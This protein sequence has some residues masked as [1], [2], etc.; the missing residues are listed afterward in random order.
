[1]PPTPIEQLLAGFGGPISAATLQAMRRVAREA[2][3]PSHLRDHAYDDQALPIGLGQT[4]SQPFIVALMTDALRLVHTDKILEIGTGSGYQAAVLAQLTRHVYTVEILQS[5]AQ[6][7]SQVLREQGCGFVRVH[8]GDGFY[9]WKEE[10][11]FDAIL[12]TCAAEQ[13]PPPLWEQLK[14][15]GR[16]VMPMGPPHYIQRLVLI[17]KSREGDIGVKLR[18]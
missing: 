13:L 6:R 17:T 11:P 4:I 2:F 18:D 7:A 8:V 14:P 10:A 1:M 5:H 9:G 12:M 3:V 15:G 16:F